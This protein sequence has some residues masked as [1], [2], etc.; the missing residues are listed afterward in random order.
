MGQPVVLV[1]SRTDCARLI[2]DRLREAKKFLSLP[3]A[4]SSQ[5]RVGYLLRSVKGAWSQKSKR[6][7]WN[8]NPIVLLEG[9]VWKPW[10]SGTS[11]SGL[12]LEESGCRPGF[13]EAILT[14]MEDP[15]RRNILVVSFWVMSAAVVSMF[16]HFDLLV[17]NCHH[18]IDVS[19]SFFTVALF[20]RK[21]EERVDYIPD[22]LQPAWQTFQYYFT[23]T[24]QSPSHRRSK[25]N[26]FIP[27]PS[28]GHAIP[29][30]NLGDSSSTATASHDLNYF[31]WLDF[32][33]SSSVLYISL[34]SV[35]SVS[36]ARTKELAAVLRVSGVRF[37]WVA[38]GE[39]TQLR[40]MCG[41]MGLVVPWCDQLKCCRILLSNSKAAV[42]DWKIGWRVKRE[43]GVETLVTR[44]ELLS[45]CG[46]LWTWNAKKEGNEE[47]SKRRDPLR[48]DRS[49]RSTWS[50][51]PSV[52]HVVAMPFPGR[53]H[54]N[55]MMN[56]CKLLASRRADILITFIVTEEW[57]GFLLSD[58]KPHKSDSVPFPTSFHPS[59][60]AAPT[61]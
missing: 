47:R 49:E 48:L 31:R 45:L 26:V 54:I 58:S 23:I 56:L 22:F 55:P 16:H 1:R 59:L 60:F 35:L 27:H 15:N 43:E 39:T 4:F 24:T 5:P 32:Q 34:G 12:K 46:D 21:G 61:T 10:I 50:P 53:G 38:L 7:N 36:R 6:V 19:V 57:L 52:A 51:A 17:Q 11:S 28:I 29:Y 3:V 40:E 42:E 20:D 44:E 33:L 18:S 14:R 2:E 41:E 30:F 8:H 37:L 13:V 9:L 25:I